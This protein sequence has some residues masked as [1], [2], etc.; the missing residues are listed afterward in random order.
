MKSV[1]SLFLFFLLAGTAL[2]KIN[3]GDPVSPDKRF[4]V[5]PRPGSTEDQLAILDSAGS[6]V[7]ALDAQD[8]ARGVGVYWSADSQRVVIFVQWKWSV[9]LCAAQITSGLWQKVEVPDFFHEVE[10]QAKPIL[11]TKSGRTWTAQQ[12]YFGSLNWLNDVAFE[13]DSTV[14]FGN[15]NSPKDP[16][17]DIK[18]FQ[19]RVKME[20]ASGIIVTNS[21]RIV[22]RADTTESATTNGITNRHSNIEDD[23]RYVAQDARLNNVYSALRAKVSPAKREQLKQMERDFLSRRDHL[24]DDPDAFFAL[25]EKQ[26]ETLQ[27]MLNSVR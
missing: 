2:C 20:F 12:D 18:E 8:S 14:S 27:Q 22:P 24:S 4:R 21:V 15:G 10:K 13:Y 25:T 1:A 16:D 11:N 3:E 26:I 5:G 19:C 17:E 6:P 23:P 9:S 7:V